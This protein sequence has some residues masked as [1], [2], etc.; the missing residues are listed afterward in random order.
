MG[1]NIVFSVCYIL[2]I[3]T[4]MKEK[5]EKLNPKQSMLI[6]VRFPN[7]VRNIYYFHSSAV[8]N[9]TFF[10]LDVDEC[11]PHQI[12][13]EYLHLA[14]KCHADANCS[15][16]KGSFYCTCHTGYSGD[17]DVCLGT[18]VGHSIKS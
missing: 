5:T 4:K 8:N 3:K 1:S 15:N 13:A 2:S 18:F 14:H 11:F 16:T 9:D 12:S 7:T 6:K 17:G 10:I